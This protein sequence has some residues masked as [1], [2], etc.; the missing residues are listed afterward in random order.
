MELPELALLANK[1]VISA[2]PQ[3]AATLGGPYLTK[4]SEEHTSELQSQAYLVCRLL[5]EKK[6]KTQKNSTIV[7]ILL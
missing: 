2:T 6:N 3:N 4:R 7:F 5:L 1:K